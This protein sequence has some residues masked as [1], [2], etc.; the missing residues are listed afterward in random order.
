MPLQVEKAEAKFALMAAML[1]MLTVMRQEN[2]NQ[3]DGVACDFS[4]SEYGVFEGNLAA[5]SGN[6]E[7]HGESL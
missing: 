3:I 2:G 5:L 4:M 6:L 7:F 1:R